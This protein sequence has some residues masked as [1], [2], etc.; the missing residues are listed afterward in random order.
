MTLNRIC[1]YKTAVLAVLMAGAFSLGAW[2]LISPTLEKQRMLDYQAELLESISTGDGVIV[3]EEHF[4]SYEVDFYTVKEAIPV[5]EAVITPAGPPE[6][7]S[8]EPA[9]AVTEVTGTGILTIDSIEAVLPVADGVSAAQLKVAVGHVP[10]TAPI[11]SE[12]NAVIAGHRSDAYGQ[13][14]NR[15]GEVALG[16]LIRYQDKNGAIFTYEVCETL[17]IEP[18]DQT[19][20]VQPPGEHLLT[21]YTCPPI[22][23]A[24]HRLLVRAKRIHLIQA[25]TE[26]FH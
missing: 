19:A 3:L 16:D 26:E 17:V 21:L 9:L 13:F 18:G 25:E 6:A 12:G 14:F 10:Q 5:A 1:L 11:G 22:R 4:D 2:Q 8:E 24:T 15:L 23:T 7:A 20:F